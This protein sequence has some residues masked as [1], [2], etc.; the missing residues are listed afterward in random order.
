MG[1]AEEMDDIRLQN[2]HRQPD[3]PIIAP[4][5]TPAVRQEPCWQAQMQLGVSATTPRIPRPTLNPSHAR[6]EEHHDE[7]QQRRDPVPA[8]RAAPAR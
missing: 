5:T 3:T 1:Y 4:D 6:T 8:H 7:R 2:M